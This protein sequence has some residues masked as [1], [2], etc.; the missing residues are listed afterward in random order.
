M[1]FLEY[2][3][4]QRKGKN[5]NRIEKNSMTDPFLYEAI[6]GFDSIDDNHI[7]RI[8][9]IKSRIRAKQTKRISFSR[10]AR[11]AAIIAVLAFAFG[12]YLFI[13][14]HKP[15]LQAQES[16]VQTIIDVYIPNN[17]YIENITSIAQRNTKTVKSTKISISRFK[18][19]ESSSHSINEK[20][21]EILE[22]A[23]K[24]EEPIDI[25]LPKGF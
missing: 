12:G 14:Y 18:V 1:K 5:A 4:G 6:D 10:F 25:Y 17:Y 24:N 15:N 22:A 13:D 20:E 2:I 21:I 23:K 9:S 19:E 7:E 11:V 16:S 8:N 3:K